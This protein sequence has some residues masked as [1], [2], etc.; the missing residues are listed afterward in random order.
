MSALFRLPLSSC[1][2]RTCFFPSSV[3]VTV[4]KSDRAGSLGTIRGLGYITCPFSLAVRTHLIPRCG[5]HPL[6]LCNPRHDFRLSLFMSCL[7]RH[8]APSAFQSLCCSQRD[9]PTTRTACATP[10]GQ[11]GPR[12]SQRG[13]WMNYVHALVASSFPHQDL[14]SVSYRTNWGI[15]MCWPVEPSGSETRLQETLCVFPLLL[16]PATAQVACWGM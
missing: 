3:F 1:P 4:P 11:T 6:S 16:D 8:V 12:E 2:P 15:E 5:L 7:A 14:A 13:E 10:S 9:V